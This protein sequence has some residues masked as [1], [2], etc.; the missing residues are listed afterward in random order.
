IPYSVGYGLTETSPL[1]AGARPS[2]TRFASTGPA[3]EG[4]QIRIDHP[5]PVTG[6]GEIL[7]RGPVVMQGYF[8]APEITSQVLDEQ[9]WLKT[10][11]LGRLDRDGYLYIKGRL[12]NVILGPSGENIYPEEVESVINRSDYVLESLVYSDNNMLTARVHLNYEKLDEDFGLK[13]VAETRVRTMVEDVL[14][15]LKESVNSQVSEFARLRKMIEQPEPFEK[16]PTQK[17]KRYL[18]TEGE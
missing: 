18:Y 7:V 13:N 4:V 2:R 10:G 6:I 15:E 1:V 3:L 14:R 12:K 9:G 8:K 5:D 16:T 11:D 17:I